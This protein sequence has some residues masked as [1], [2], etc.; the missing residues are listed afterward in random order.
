MLILSY[1]RITQQKIE[2]SFLLS[3][4]GTRKIDPGSMNCI[5]LFV[6]NFLSFGFMDS[7]VSSLFKHPSVIIKTYFCKISYHMRIPK[8][9]CISFSF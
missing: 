9:N 6:Q 2:L 4:R 3:G 5:S 8:F 1:E 7:P